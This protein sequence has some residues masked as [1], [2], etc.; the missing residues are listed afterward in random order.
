MMPAAIGQ[1]WLSAVQVVA[2]VGQLVG[3]GVGVGTAA[4][5]QAGS[6]RG[7]PE[8]AGYA[9]GAAGEDALG[10]AT[11]PGLG[12]EEPVCGHGFDLL[13]VTIGFLLED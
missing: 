5:F 12:D 13:R 10:A 9:G 7:S 1:P 2:F 6:G 3:A 11:Y 8:G 4:G